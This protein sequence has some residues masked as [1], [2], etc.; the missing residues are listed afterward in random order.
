MMTTTHTAPKFSTAANRWYVV[1]TS[2]PTLPAGMWRFVSA[3]FVAKCQAAAA[4][5]VNAA[6][7]TLTKVAGSSDLRAAQNAYAFHGPAGQT[8]GFSASS[9]TNA[10][11]KVRRNVN[12]F[13]G[14]L[15]VKG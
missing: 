3:D 7:A 5:L 1:L 11:R 4:V 13:Y 9:H 6:Q 8:P 12:N 15:R 2:H 10:A 14:P